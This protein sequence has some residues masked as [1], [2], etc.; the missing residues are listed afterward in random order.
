MQ[1]NKAL[2]HLSG[3]GVNQALAYWVAE[4]SALLLSKRRIYSSRQ[5][6]LAETARS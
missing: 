1:S 2:L 4:F 6:G 3:L 5:S